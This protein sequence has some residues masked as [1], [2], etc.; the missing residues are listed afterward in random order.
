MKVTG[1]PIVVS[2]LG[3][4]TWKIKDQKKDGD[5]HIDKLEYKESWR[6]EEIRGLPNF[7]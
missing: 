5:Q 1:I 3:T 2:S 6:P 7:N 4:V